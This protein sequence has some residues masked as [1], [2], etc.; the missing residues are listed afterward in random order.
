MTFGSLDLGV[1]TPKE[2]MFSQGAMAMLSIKSKLLLSPEEIT[3]NEFETLGIEVSY[4]LGLLILIAKG[5]EFL[6]LHFYKR[7]MFETQGI[8]LKYI[9]IIPCQIVLVNKNSSNLIKTRSSRIK[10]L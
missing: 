5:N 2:A 4:W 3:L 6:I 9:S 7:T 10:F 1:L 8:D